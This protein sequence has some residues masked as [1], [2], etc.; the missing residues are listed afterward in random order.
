MLR[1]LT[2]SSLQGELAEYAT[3]AHESAQGL[4]SLLNGILDLS[5]IE[6]GSME[7]ESIATNLPDLFRGVGNMMSIAIEEKGLAFHCDIDPTTPEW[8]L[9]DPVRIRQVLVNLIGNATKFTSDGSVRLR[10]WSEPLADPQLKRIFM[11]VQ[12]SGIGIPKERQAALFSPFTQVDASTTR[13]FGGTGLGLAISRELAQLMG[14]E[15]T[16]E[17]TMG[18]GSTFTVS[19]NVPLC[20]PPEQQSD[21]PGTTSLLK[22]KSR[23][24]LVEDNKV[25]QKIASVMMTKLHLDLDIANDGQEAVQLLAQRD[26]DVVL[27]D[28]QMP[29]MDGFEATACIRL[30]EQGVRQPDIPIIAMTANAMTGDRDQ[31]L[32]VG[33]NDYISKPIDPQLFHEILGKWLNRPR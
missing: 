6:A 5:K 19:M 32:E 9:C 26:Y 30:G 16:L 25:N 14:G 21:N 11:A 7:L 28:C 20:T 17:S 3:M 4:L 13:K 18:T 22:G 23:V 10:T 31:C 1:L 12:D 2:E 33:M 8:V 29:V 24:L 15:V 27:M